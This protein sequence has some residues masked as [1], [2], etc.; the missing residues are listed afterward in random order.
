VVN[1]TVAGLPKLIEENAI[2][3]PAVIL[4]GAVAALP[5]QQPELQGTAI[6]S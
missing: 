6:A 4:I 1:G 3:G 2:R 5:L